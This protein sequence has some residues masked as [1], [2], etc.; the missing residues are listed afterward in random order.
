MCFCFTSNENFLFSSE[1][2]ETPKWVDFLQEKDTF[3]KYHGNRRGFHRKKLQ[4]Q[5]TLEIITDF[6]CE[7]KNL[8]NLRR[9]RI[10]SAFFIFPHFLIFHS[11]SLSHSL[12]LSLCLSV[13]LFPTSD[14]PCFMVCSVCTKKEEKRSKT[15][16]CYPRIPID[17]LA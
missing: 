12:T 1:N 5:Q 3:R 7:A 8:I 10:F 4:Q 15:T 17:S 14:E 6:A 2:G 13:T 11:L 9:F 16:T